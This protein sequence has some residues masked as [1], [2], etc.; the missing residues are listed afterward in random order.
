MWFTLIPDIL[1][2][3]GEPLKPLTE[4]VLSNPL[5][6]EHTMSELWELC[7]RRDAY[8]AAYSKHW[9]SHHIDVLLCPVGPGPAPRHDTA[10]YWGY[11]AQWN[12][13]DYPAAVFPTG[14]RATGTEP[15]DENF[16]A[17]GED[18]QINHDACEYYKSDPPVKANQCLCGRQTGVLCGCTAKS[19]D[20]IEAVQR[21]TCH[22]RR[23]PRG[24]CSARCTVASI[25][26]I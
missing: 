15:F 22:G 4:W 12:L 20:C 7:V 19:P 16:E 21:R 6:R 25:V 14:L 8:R 1:A 2:A 23:D 9:N 24:P 3:N 17:F 10:K 13:L 11:T 26:A 18:D 5:V